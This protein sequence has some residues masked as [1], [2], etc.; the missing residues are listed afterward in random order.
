MAQARTPRRRVDGVLLL[1]KPTGATSNA[2]LQIAKRLY[3]AEKAGHTG[4]LDPLASGLLPL[5]FG[6]ATKFAQRLLDAPKAYEA[7]IRFG[8][9]TTTGDAEGEVLRCRA[10]G[11][12]REALAEALRRFVGEQDQLPPMH[13]ALKFEGRAYYEHAR[14]GREI[15]RSPR[16]IRVDALD[17]VEW[18]SPDAVVAVRCSKGTYVRVLAEDIGEAL[19]CGAHLA[20]LRRT[21]TGGFSIAQA[22]TVEALEAM[23]PAARDAALLPASSLVAGMPQL[24]IGAEEARRFRQGQSV[25]A[26]GT[27]TGECAVFAGGDFLG[28]AQVANGIAKPRRVIAPA[29]PPSCR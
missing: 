26:A 21:A 4:T 10:V 15:P 1:D 13:S 18:A 8:V 27:A 3:R 14:A 5:C 28:I 12:T 2:A 23:S 17:L 22:V 16:R 20:A 19:G 6:E 9:T 7:T 24:A 11:V 25:Q 29:A